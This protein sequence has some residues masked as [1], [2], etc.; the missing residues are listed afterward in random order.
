MIINRFALVIKYQISGFLL[1]IKDSKNLFGV[2]AGGLVILGL[3][4]D[5]YSSVLAYF[6]GLTD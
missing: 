6:I 2:K 4:F 3:S 5:C 1:F